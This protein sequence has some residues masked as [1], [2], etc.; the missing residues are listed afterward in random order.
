MTD[1]STTCEVVIFGVKVSCTAS[2]HGIKLAMLLDLS[3]RDVL[4]MKARNVIGAF[5]S[6]FFHS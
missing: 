4:A 6:I 2:V 3:I 1:V 5:R